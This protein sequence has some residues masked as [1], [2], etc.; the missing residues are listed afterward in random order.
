MNY[1][2]SGTIETVSVFPIDLDCTVHTFNLHDSNLK[3][4]KVHTY[5]T[6]QHHFNNAHNRGGSN[7]P[8]ETNIFDFFF[9]MKLI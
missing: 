9:Q 6:K 3:R 2:D 5:H 7:C 8:Q 4:L 1:D